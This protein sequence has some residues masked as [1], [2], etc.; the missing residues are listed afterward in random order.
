MCL[1]Y[2]QNESGIKMPNGEM[3]SWKSAEELKITHSF[4]GT[5]EMFDG[6]GY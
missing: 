4:S 1:S 6:S 2:K 3:L 5:A